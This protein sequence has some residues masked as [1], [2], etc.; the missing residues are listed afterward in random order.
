[1]WVTTEKRKGVTVTIYIYDSKIDA[2]E[3]SDDSSDAEKS[4]HLTDEELSDDSPDAFN[5]SLSSSDSLPIR[6]KQKTVSKKTVKSTGKKS[7]T[8]AKQEKKALER[9]A[10]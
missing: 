2:S 4:V 8:T 3:S 7:S 6:K 9:K 1:M 10:I 5:S